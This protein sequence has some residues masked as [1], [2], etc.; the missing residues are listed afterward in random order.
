M[1]I[2]LTR[3]TIAVILYL[4]ELSIT[5]NKA[6]ASTL[7]IGPNGSFVE[8]INSL[9]IY[10]KKIFQDN[11]DTQNKKLNDLKRRNTKQKN[12]AKTNSEDVLKSA[13]DL[14]EQFGTDNAF[15]GEQPTNNQSAIQQS[16]DIESV[17]TGLINP[18]LESSEQIDDLLEDIDADKINGDI[19][20]RYYGLVEDEEISLLE[21]N[22]L[23]KEIL[24]NELST[25]STPQNTLKENNELTR[26]LVAPDS[27]TNSN[28]NS[29]NKSEEDLQN[30]LIQNSS[31][32][33]FLGMLLGGGAIA[34]L[35]VKSLKSSEDKGIFGFIFNL[36]SKPKVPDRAIELHN[37]HFKKLSNLD[38][39]LQ[40]IDSDSFLSQEFVLYIQLKSKINQGYKQRELICL[41]IRYLEIGILAQSSFL[42]LEQTELRYRSSKQQSFYN[43]VAENITDDIDKE[44]FRRKI[45]DKLTEITPLI[46]TEEG[47]NALRSYFQEVSEIS[48][49]DLG[50]KLLSLFKKYQLTDFTI[51]RRVSDIVEQSTAEN[52]LVDDNLKLVVLEN[53]ETLKKLAPIIEM[54]E[55]E[56]TTQFFTKILQYLSLGRKH[57]KA[58]Q[59]FQSLIKVLKQWKTP[60]DSL[61]VIRQEYSDSEYSLPK[62]FRQE[63]PGLSIYKKYQEYLEK[64]K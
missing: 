18:K 37:K 41:S 63:I 13:K 25:D 23:T 24:E 30:E 26:Q 54:D 55:S 52:L 7:F 6:N 53:Y 11:T 28:I 49:Y 22:Q 31:K 1:K 10:Q 39:K 5:Y 21:S 32:G 35:T 58:F 56:I 14:Q 59:N 43:F 60:Y 45:E 8:D 15:L 47:K 17:N 20:D 64:N 50:L 36:F 29:S 51:L 62:E 46:N 3:V 40:K 9:S 12:A 27:E 61:T 16:I 34:L 48:Q 42:R 57:E 44:V 19:R 38:K 2:Y 33:I 4:L